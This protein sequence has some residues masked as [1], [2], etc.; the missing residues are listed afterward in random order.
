M[1]RK[2][3]NARSRFLPSES[4]LRDIELMNLIANK[5]SF[6]SEARYQGRCQH[7][8][9]KTPNAAWQPHHVIYA[10]HIREINAAVE[11]DT[12][13]AMR[14]CLRCHGR[15]HNRKAPVPTTAI[16]CETIEFAVEL[17]G[18]GRALGYFER[19]YDTSQDDARLIE[20]AGIA[21]AA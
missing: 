1:A 20:L 15:Q 12:R 9:C 16:R 10:Q 8:A 11:Y 17:M 5:G 7:P 14:L 3:K 2:H 13:D 21:D 6:R 19:Y 4:E 18:A